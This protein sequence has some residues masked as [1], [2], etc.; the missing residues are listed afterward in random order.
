MTLH[1]INFRPKFETKVISGEKKQTIRPVPKQPIMVG[2]RLRLYT[3]LRQKWK[4]SL[5][6]EG[7][8]ITVAPICINEDLEIWINGTLL[9]ANEAKIIARAD[10]FSELTLMLHWFL[11]E[12]GLPFEGVL[13][14]WL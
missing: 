5:L 11:K 1:V 13:I 14:R 6:R 4:T 3:G 8:V 9:D 10:G 12:H 7:L 2:D